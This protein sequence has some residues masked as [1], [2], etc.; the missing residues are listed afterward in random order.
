LPNFWCQKIE[1]KDPG[2]VPV[3]TASFFGGKFLSFG[4]FFK[5]IKIL[6]NIPLQ[7]AKNRGKKKSY[8]IV[9]LFRQVTRE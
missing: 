4:S 2:E 5:K 8:K 3:A 7:T 9:T 1:Q 6:S